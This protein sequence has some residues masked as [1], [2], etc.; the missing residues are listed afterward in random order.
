M[1][2]KLSKSFYKN[3]FTFKAVCLAFD[4]L[5]VQRTH[6]APE[7]EVPRTSSGFFLFFEK[8][9]NYAGIEESLELYCVVH[10][11]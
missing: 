6:K 8:S 2:S 7:Q 4:F 9:N 10:V 11:I 3:M 1:D 5:N